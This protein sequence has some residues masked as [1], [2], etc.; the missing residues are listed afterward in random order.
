MTLREIV[1]ALTTR[2]KAAS[3]SITIPEGWRLEQTPTI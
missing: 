2:R 1:E 3:V